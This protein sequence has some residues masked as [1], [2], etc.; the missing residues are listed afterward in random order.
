M[1][2]C[3]LSHRTLMVTL[4]FLSVVDSMQHK[5]CDGARQRAARHPSQLAFRHFAVPDS[6]WFHTQE[7]H[8]NAHCSFFYAPGVNRPKL[9]ITKGRSKV[10]N[11]RYLILMYYPN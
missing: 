7:D 6:C 11:R 3:G 1:V 10:S 4:R 9:V 2:P 5:R 8:E